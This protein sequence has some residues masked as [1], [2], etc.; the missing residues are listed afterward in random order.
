MLAQVQHN[1]TSELGGDLS[2]GVESDKNKQRRERRQDKTQRW[3]EF[4]NYFSC[5][6]FDNRLSRFRFIWNGV[7]FPSCAHLSFSLSN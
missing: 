3:F 1:I 4:I 2:K 7:Y 5:K 6:N